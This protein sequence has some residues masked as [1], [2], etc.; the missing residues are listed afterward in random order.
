MHVGI[1]LW[2]VCLCFNSG[3]C[4]YAFAPAVFVRAPGVVSI[5]NG[6]VHAT[7]TLTSPQ[8]V[9]LAGFSGPVHLEGLLMMLKPSGR[10]Q[11]QAALLLPVVQYRQPQSL[12]AGGLQIAGEAIITLS[13]FSWILPSDASPGGNG[14]VSLPQ[15][16][17]GF[18]AAVVQWMETQRNAT[19]AAANSSSPAATNTTN[20][21]TAAP[22]VTTPG[23]SAAPESAPGDKGRTCDA[24]T[25]LSPQPPVSV[26]SQTGSSCSCKPGWRGAGCSSCTASNNAQC[27]SLLQTLKDGDASAAEGATCS[28]TMLYTPASPYRL[29]S[30]QVT[31]SM[32]SFITQSD[33]YCSLTGAS[34]SQ[35]TPCLCV[36]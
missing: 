27:G 17:P 25:Q 1:L 18:Q 36:S 5:I 2:N 6:R 30:C 3:F 22:A 26:S 35:P 32:T 31:G 8:D 7:S 29:L 11:P 13:L 24:V 4:M 10:T 33:F 9:S 34:R 15:L 23:P 14:A 28:A 19:Q 21:T 20:G 16:D 12:K